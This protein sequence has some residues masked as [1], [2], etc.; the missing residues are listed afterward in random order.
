MDFAVR[1]EDVYKEYPVYQHITAGFKS[2]VFNLPK[3]IASFKK[4][5][6]TALKGITFEVQKGETFGIVG[7]NGSGKSTILELSAGVIR[8]NSGLIK[9]SGRISSLLELGAGFHPD[10]SGIENI[11]LNGILMGNTRHDMLKKME[12]IIEFS[13]L[14]DF[15][16]QP[17]RTYSSGMYVR[18]G[19]SVAVHIDPDILLIDEA[20][21][22]GDLSFQEKCLR[23]IREFKESGATIIIVS[24]NL[25]MIAKL[26]DRAAWIDSG[27]IMAVGEPEKV[28]TLYLKYLGQPVDIPLIKEQPRAV[29]SEQS[30]PDESTDI[31][32]ST[33]LPDKVEHLSWWDSPV[34]LKRC[35]EH[36]TGDPSVHFY[37]FLK[38]QHQISSFEKGLCLCN[39]LKGIS[40]NF[41]SYGICKSF[42]VIDDKDKIKDII[43]G[44]YELKKEYYNLFLCIDAL[45]SIEKLELFLEKIHHSLKEEGF[46]V[47]LEYIGP[48]N[49]QWS[50]EEI[51]IADTICTALNNAVEKS[52]SLTD[53]FSDNKKT[54]VNSI[55]VI[56]LIRKFFE[57]VTIK[58]FGSPLYNLIF[59]KIL[60]RFDPA[61]SK[62]SV[63][64][65]TIMQVEQVLIKNGLLKNTHALIIARKISN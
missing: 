39:R 26:C 64:I 11:I 15:I 13:E 42:D 5:K 61:D 54:A 59:N 19:F 52:S 2:F 28:I 10:L 9:S 6:F 7:R 8:Q 18:L 32:D 34:I 53:S 21:A 43:S 38:K 46:V 4:N 40:N 27:S 30:P 48:V 1:F 12:E 60:Y 41:I 36:I 25:S 58:Y 49:F 24:H 16:Y 50:A 17:L 65:N 3:N 14:G 22:V 47:A 31:Q 63:M 35:E 44:T 29:T 33:G 56:P 51:G 45:N 20:L 55:N 23:R 37:D 62:D 57:I